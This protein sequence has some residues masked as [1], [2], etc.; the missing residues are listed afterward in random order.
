MLNRI[1]FFWGGECEFLI[2][3]KNPF[4]NGLAVNISLSKIRTTKLFLECFL[5]VPG[6]FFNFPFNLF[7]QAF[8]LLFLAAYQ[9][10]SFFLHFSSCIFDCAFYLIFIHGVLLI[11]IVG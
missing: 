4:M 3:I 7:C 6:S 8:G 1:G 11:N 2:Y 9:F 5:D 10:S